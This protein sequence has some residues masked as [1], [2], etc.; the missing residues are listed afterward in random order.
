MNLNRLND[1]SVAQLDLL[2][3]ALKTIEMKKV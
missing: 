2:G 3:A 1:D